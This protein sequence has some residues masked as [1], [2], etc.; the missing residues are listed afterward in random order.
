MRKSSGI[1]SISELEGKKS[2]H[3][4]FGRN[5]GWKIPFSHLMD[6]KQLPRFCD[7]IEAT[8]PEKD[9]YAISNYF[10]HACAPGA[11]V[12]ERDKDRELSK[13]LKEFFLNFH[14]FE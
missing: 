6:K 10:K 11:W 13:F 5:A 8:T 1:T 2:C 4:G 12:P 14:N 7:A 9:L 3:T